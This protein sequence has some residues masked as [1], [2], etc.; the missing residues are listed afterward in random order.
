MFSAPG[1]FSSNHPKHLG[2][3]LILRLSYLWVLP[4]SWEYYRTNGRFKHLIESRSTCLVSRIRSQAKFNEVRLAFGSGGCRIIRMAAL[5]PVRRARGLEGRSLLGYKE[6]GSAHP[7]IP[8]H[9]LL[10]NPAID[11]IV[12]CNYENPNSTH[13]PRGVGVVEDITC[14]PETSDGISCAF[15]ALPGT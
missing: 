8:M 9:A 15:C 11:D 2:H 1:N 5:R 14:F 12:D 10:N 6:P 7:Y 4:A 3:R 13:L